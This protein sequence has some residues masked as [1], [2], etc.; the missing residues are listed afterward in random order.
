MTSY[1][2][3]YV[4]M[5][6]EG[7]Y[8]TPIT[9]ATA[10]GEVDDEGF[11]ESFDVLSRPDMNRYGASKALDSKHYADG[12]YSMPL[13]PDR[14]TMMSLHGLFGTHTAGGTAGTDDTLTEVGAL[15]SYT[16]LVGRDD[17]AF[18]YAGQVISDCSISASVGEYAMI[19]FNT[20]GMR[21]QFNLSNGATVALASLA[22]PSY[23]YTGDAAH[24]VGAY[25]N[26]EDVASTSAYSKLVQSISIDIKTNRDMDN[27]YGLGDST[28][29][30]AP[31]I[32]LREITGSITFHKNVL[33]GDVATDE[34]DFS[35]L[36]AGEFH[37]GTATNPA[38]SVLFY[39]DA[40]NKIRLD[41]TKVHYEAP[42]TNV[43]GR[44]QQTM[45]VNFMGLYDA[46]TTSMSKITF[47]S[48]STAFTGGAKV[49]LDA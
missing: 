36:I 1:A 39:V 28:C 4:S 26:F 3:R 2:N 16:Y 17:N 6:K 43:S 41:V 33:T 24:F 49:D 37:D 9:T 45:S 13:Q 44:D 7:T 14:F 8:G 48:T 35:S 31:P 29:T 19:S 47:S 11:T 12:S 18:T 27:S 15:P 23:D 34:V 21:S 5:V 22:S 20:T 30:R 42:T 32:G 25:V 38:L 46:G 40:N 10:F